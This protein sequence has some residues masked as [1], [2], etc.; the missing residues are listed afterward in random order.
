MHDERKVLQDRCT[1]GAFSN[2]S[3]RIAIYR[4]LGSP[5]HRRRGM[6]ESQFIWAGNATLMAGLNPFSSGLTLGEPAMQIPDFDAG[7]IP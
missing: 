7:E 1:V 4:R 3:G 2:R 5:A 6:P